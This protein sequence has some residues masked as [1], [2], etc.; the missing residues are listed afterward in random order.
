M[1]LG[2]KSGVTVRDLDNL[3]QKAER[4]LND[5]HRHWSES[6][7]EHMREF[8]ELKLQSCVFQYDVCLEMVNVVRNRPSGFARCVALK[9]LVLRLF[10]YSQLL[11]KD[12]IPRLIAL[13]RERH[14]DLDRT[15]IGGMRKRWS[16]ELRQLEGW[17]D[18]RNEA[19]GHYGRDISRQVQLLESLDLDRVMGVARA[20]LS[21]NMFL[22]V[23]LRDAGLG[24]G[25][26]R[27]LEG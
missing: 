23:A 19:A 27:T 6:R 1:S 17:S 10:E 8:V 7:D 14:S 11:N 24:G 16:L 4:N 3:V 5:S 15:R 20:F 22:L 26:R 18:V 9:G 25:E 2:K 13:A 21:L 12:F